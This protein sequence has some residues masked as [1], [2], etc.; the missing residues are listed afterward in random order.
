MKYSDRQLIIKIIEDQI[1][2]LTNLLYLSENSSQTVQLDQSA[3]GRVSRID[4]IQQQKMAAS[5][6]IRDKNLVTRLE[7]VLTKLKN[8]SNQ[9]ESNFGYCEECGEEILF[10]RLKIKPDSEYCIDCQSLLD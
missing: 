5:S 6:M 10:A 7:L 1:R 2:E 3:N 4:A 9:T 8:D